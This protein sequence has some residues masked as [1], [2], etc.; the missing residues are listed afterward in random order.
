MA[1]QTLIQSQLSASH[2]PAASQASVTKCP[3]LA[4]QMNDGNSNVF[5]KASLEL[6]EDVQE[7]HAVRKGNDSSERFIL[8]FSPNVLICLAQLEEAKR[9]KILVNSRVCKRFLCVCFFS[10]Q[11]YWICQIWIILAFWDFCIC[12]ICS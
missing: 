6:Q 1:Q 2:P 5:C 7:M 3:F 12:F 8:L 4:A 9:S 11:P 10:V